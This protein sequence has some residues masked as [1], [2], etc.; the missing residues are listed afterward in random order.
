MARQQPSQCSIPSPPSPR[1]SHTIYYPASAPT[2]SKNLAASRKPAQ[3]SPAP[4]PS[5]AT[6]ANAN[7]SSDEQKPVPTDQQ[8]PNR[9]SGPSTLVAAGH[10]T[11]SLAAGA[12]CLRQHPEVS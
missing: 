6:R 7:S 2:S 5:P 10:N 3:N 12:I 1:S 4:P 9:Q 11:T 8:A